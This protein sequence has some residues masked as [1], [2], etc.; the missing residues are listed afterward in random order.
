MMF[1][2][3]FFSFWCIMRS[4]NFARPSA[5][6]RAYVHIWLFVIAWA[7]L[8]VVTVA[9]DR[10]QVS[11]GYIF[12][13]WASQVFIATLISFLEFFS[14]QKKKVFALGAQE[15]QDVR[16]HLH[17]VPHS[18]AIIAPTPSEID[19]E[20]AVHDDDSVEAEQ[21]TETSPLMGGD[22]RG[23]T[24]TT[25]ATGY[26]RSIAALVKASTRD[27][28]KDGPSPFGYEQEWS[29]HLTSWTWILQFL[30]L[31]PFM[32]ILTAQLGLLLVASVYQT[33]ADGSDTLR[34]YLIIAIFSMLL[35]FPATPFVH[36]VT[37]HLPLFLF[38]V[39]VGTLT[40]NLIAFPFSPTSP[41]KIYFRQLISLDTGNTT[42]MFTG[43]E[44][45]ARMII[46]DIPSANGKSV[47]CVPSS[48]RS[49]GLV[50]CTYDGSSVAPNPGENVSEG[51]PPQT[52]YH[53]LVTINA[54]R[55]S[56]KNKATFTINSLNTKTCVMRFKRP[57]SHA[58]VHGSLGWDG[59][60][61]SP[62]DKDTKLTE[63]TLWRRDWTTPWVVD[64]EWEDDEDLLSDGNAGI[65]G[66]TL[67]VPEHSELR[68]GDDSTKP[69]SVGLDGEVVCRWSDTN[70][71]GVIPALDEAWQFA[72]SWSIVSVK[73][74]PGLIEGTKS[75][76]I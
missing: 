73:S 14:L 58:F 52:G 20:T 1:S 50:D 22:T 7:V 44:E 28:S 68:R 51:F 34:P 26:R 55:P 54:T 29:G 30:I 76:M 12:V 48:G 70:T 11:S 19:G 32:I 24:R 74:K 56:L 41:C 39:F 72:P 36:R 67:D 38:L 47:S 42:V 65:V 13:F 10:M 40:Y 75:F 64:V 53:K 57:V 4:A 35:L 27:P 18:D 62:S 60:Y 46:A 25:F 2:L 66:S 43:H 8:V 15:D 23:N 17:A 5:L 69:R 16:D 71:P 49:T 21:P 63:F 61:E 31:G 45:Y 59:R 3:S 6:H 9:E 37:R 33:G